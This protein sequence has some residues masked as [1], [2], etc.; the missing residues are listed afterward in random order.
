MIMRTENLLIEIGTEELPPKALKTLAQSFQDGMAQAL[1]D[2]DLQFTDIHYHAAPRR[3]GLTVTQL[4]HVQMDKIIEK[5][6]PALTAAFDHDGNPTRA[7]LGWAKSNGIDIGQAQRLVTDKGEWLLH[8]S[9]QTGQNIQVLL[10]GLVERALKTLPIP[11]PMRW[12]SSNVQ[13]I[14]PVQTVCAL[15][16]SQLIDI[17]I[18]GKQS[19]RTIHGHRFHGNI[20]LELNHADD[21]VDALKG[22]FVL[23]DFAERKGFIA[24]S[25]ATNAADLHLTADFDDAL[26]DEITALVEWPVVMCASFDKSFLNVP[27]E[28]LIY[29]MKDDQ[30]YVPLIET[31]G[32]LASTFLFVANIDSHQPELV[33]QG[34]ERVIRPRLA[35]AQFFFE[36]D[37][38][39]TLESRMNSLSS[40]VF[41]KQLG[42]LADKSTR[43]S[44]SAGKIAAKLK[45]NVKAAQRAGLLS[46]TDLMTNMV[47]EFPDVQGVMGFHYA[48]NDGESPAVA[49]A[50]FEQ[51]LPRF[52]GDKIAS[53]PVSVSVA[54][55]DKLDT[56]VGIFG[57]GQLP[58]GDKD[59]FA[60]RRAAIGVLR[61]IVDNQLDLDLVD[62]IDFADEALQG[63]LN[64]NNAI[65]T[66][67]LDFII[68]RFKA[69]YQDA[70]VS[71]DVIQ[72]VTVKS[73]TCP[74]DFDARIKAIS[75]FKQNPAAQSLAAAHKRA[76]NIL[77]KNSDLSIPKFDPKLLIDNEEIVLHRALHDTKEATKIGLKCND[78]DQVLAVMAEL[79]DPVDAF[80]DNVMV[81]TEDHSVKQNRLALL[82][83]LR[84]VFEYIADISLLVVK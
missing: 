53:D 44:T 30:K 26:L 23:A 7:A 70:G 60:L 16:G 41:Q 84:Q 31:D 11:K 80:F 78:Y 83:E 4:A 56:L 32:S 39:Y 17:C 77:N 72:A 61:T 65:K 6:G 34:N 3:L 47:M 50:L 22:E 54:L 36:T 59:P 37:K 71:V 28:A 24:E 21:Y 2:A 33:V 75:T 73:P 81:M 63:K 76:A 9:H 27:K 55:A 57:I 66:D 49:N 25:L 14:R 20:T 67:V 48:L 35:D 43:I 29:T 12:G 18:L 69:I 68:N 58:K 74:S 15:Y 19:S 64:S 51:Y 46:K 1:N 79:K 42:T 82:T 10:Q 62:L 40:V 52:A 38:K 5:R 8:K 45:G 13:F